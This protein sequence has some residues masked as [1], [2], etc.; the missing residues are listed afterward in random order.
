[1]G[2]LNQG[3]YGFTAK[4]HRRDFV[5]RGQGEFFRRLPGYFHLIELDIHLL[6]IPDPDFTRKKLKLPVD[7]IEIIVYSL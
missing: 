4:Q 1:M 6:F 5:W 3:E 2:S 7:K